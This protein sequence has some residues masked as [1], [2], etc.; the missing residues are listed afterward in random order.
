[1]TRKLPEAH[2]TQQQVPMVAVVLRTMV[3]MVPRTKIIVVPTTTV[4]KIMVHVVDVNVAE[5]D[6]LWGM[7]IWTKNHGNYTENHGYHDSLSNLPST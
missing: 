1:M 5:H 6:S 4:P 7:V 3:K 2:P